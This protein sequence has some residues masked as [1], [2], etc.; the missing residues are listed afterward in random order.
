MNRKITFAPGEFYHAYNR[1]V[2]KR[3]IFIDDQDYRRFIQLLF[4]ANGRKAFEYRNIRERRFSEIERDEPLVAIGAYCLIPN[5]F[6]LLVK[7]I[8]DSGLSDFMETL[9]IL[10]RNMVALG[11]YF[12]EDFR[13]ST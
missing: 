1:G 9:N 4:V 7:E 12:R 3:E 10:I 8:T 6:H 11:R 5:H 2:D 13:H